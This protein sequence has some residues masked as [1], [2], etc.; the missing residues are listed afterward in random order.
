MDK[1]KLKVFLV[2]FFL[3]VSGIIGVQLLYDDETAFFDVILVADGRE[4]SVHV[5]LKK[6]DSVNLPVLTKE[7]YV[8]K[9]WEYNG[10]L[11][12]GS[13]TFNEVDDVELVAVFQALTY[14]V[15]FIDYD[16]GVLKEEIVNYSESA[17]APEAPHREGYTFIE[18]SVPFDEITEDLI[19][20]AVYEAHTY[21]VTFKDF[22]DRVVKE[23]TVNYLESANAPE[24]PHRDGYTF[25]E[26]S[27][28]FDEVTE[29]LVVYAVYE[30]SIY[31][32]IFKDYDEKVLKE[33]TVNYLDSATAPEEPDREGH[34]FIE[35]SLS[36]DEVTEDLIVYAVYETNTY[37][38]IFRDYD[39]TVLKEEIVN[40]LG[41]ATAPEEPDREGHTFLEWS[42]LFDEITEDL[43]VYAVYE[44]ITYTVTFKDF[45][46]T[47]LKVDV[48][49]YLENATAPEEPDREGYSFLEWSSD[50]DTITEDL[51]IYAVYSKDY[52]TITIYDEHGSTLTVHEDLEFGT[53][54]S[55]PTITQ[56]DY[57][58]AYWSHQGEAFID[59]VHVTQDLSLEPV[60][61]NKIEDFTYTVNGDQVTIT[62]YIGDTPNVI[63]PRFY[64]DKI[65]TTIAQDAFN[66]NNHIQSVTI[67]NTVTQIG[68]NA[69]RNM[70]A[71]TEV[72]FEAGSQ[73]TLI[74]NAAFRGSGALSTMNLEAAT[75]LTRIGEGAFYDTNL[76]ELYLSQTITHIGTNA[77]RNTA[78]ITVYIGRTS[79]TN[80]F[81]WNWNTSINRV[82]YNT[83]SVHRNDEYVY[84]ER[85]DNTIVIMDYIETNGP[86]SLT[87][88]SEINGYPVTFI[89][90][91]AFNGNNH[92]QQVTIPNTVT[93]I[94]VNA[95]RNM[96]ALTEVIFEAG[97]QL[98]LIDNAAF[99]DSGALSTMNLEEAKVLTQI[100]E[101]AFYDTNLS[102]LYIS[103]TITH[104]G[105]NAF[106]YTSNITVYIGRTS[107][108]NGFAWNWNASINRVL[109]NTRSVH[110]NDEYVYA[111]R[112]DNTIVIMDY[113]ETNG[114]A[115]L[116][117]P[118]E[119]NGYPV[120][121]IGKDAF[122]GNNHI[123][124][125]TIPNTV[126]QI[127]VN[128]FRN[129]NALTEV[130]FEAGSQLTLIDNAAFRDSGALST[131][132][133]EEAK[134]LTQIG[135]GAFYDT[136]LSELYLSQTITHIGTHAFR[137]TANMTLYIGRTSSTNGFA[138]QWS[139]SV[140]EIIYGITVEDYL[141]TKDND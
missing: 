140:A 57:V 60:F 121:F 118:S 36:F 88:P 134:V 26:W 3:V 59:E 95:F 113:I 21:T 34:R 50:Y 1:K 55:L 124:S 70:N 87:V 83:R 77:F 52:Y 100:G 138:W 65:I 38:V 109:Y 63:I 130:I 29:D 9:G 39:D 136:N 115:S 139:A 85:Y 69:F 43:I 112:Y 49:G 35:W 13:I 75:V 82:L 8:F 30:P 125:V 104:I 45:D 106:R 81:A 129:M 56:D 128:A 73:L 4:H 123:Q 116:T 90:K 133:L 64:G 51:I 84:A 12:H 141:A 74:D 15:T 110:R 97:S 78:N 107:S 32:V 44:A 72:I 41:S 67:P 96:N 127:G 17:N 16:D 80:G 6:G 98:T 76:S 99:R 79:S 18:W 101:G 62:E 11:H 108:T 91:D 23:E 7:H 28:S 93:Q 92:I 31:T 71:L 132:N 131:M 47:I 14:T 48:V 89:G 61:T 119:I 5:N 20:Y 117:V 2:V 122:N 103:Q 37:T 114:P 86:A 10:E 19:V 46:E 120:T 33:E 42:V 102:E 54:I 24:A 22:D 126:T 25:I 53:I 111:E 58:F 105:T 68:V 135:E 66:G 27:L 40:Y 94:G 137:Y